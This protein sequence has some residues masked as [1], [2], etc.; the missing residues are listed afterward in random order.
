MALY[1]P[2]LFSLLDAETPAPYEAEGI[3]EAVV[4]ASAALDAGN[5]SAA[6]QRFI[7]YW[8]GTRSWERTADQRRASIAASV[9]NA[10]DSSRSGQRSDCAVSAAELIQRP[11][12][13]HLAEPAS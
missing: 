10:G 13:G 9:R 12:M 8:M 5:E 2:T 6:A 7:D 1:E 4:D 3:R 11:S